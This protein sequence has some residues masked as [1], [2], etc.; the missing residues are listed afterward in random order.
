MRSEAFWH[1]FETAARPRLKLRGASFARI[2]EH[3]DRFDR[4]VG[5]IETGCMRRREAEL[6]GDGGSTILF[7]KY[8]E[9]HPGSTVHT[10]DIDMAATAMCRELA[11]DRVAIAR[12]DSVAFLHGFA[13]SPPRGFM[14]LDL[15]Y[16]DASDFDAASTA[17]GLHHLRELTAAQPLLHEDTLVVVDE[18]PTAMLGVPRPDGGFVVIGTPG[19]GGKGSLVAEY[20]SRIG[21]TFAVQGF[22]AG[23]TAM[24]RGASQDR[25]AVRAVIA[26]SPQGL[27]AVGAAD[28]FVGKSQ[29]EAGGYGHEEI[30]RAAGLLTPG[31]DVLVVGAHVGSIAIPLARRCRHLT[32]VEANPWTSKLLR[33]NL[34]LN[35]AN[36]VTAH[37]FAASD[38]AGT[39][40][41]VMNT[42]NSGGSKRYPLKPDPAY[43]YDD[44]AIVDVPCFALDEKLD[45]HDFVSTA[46]ERPARWRRKS[47]PVL[48]GFPCS[49]GGRFLVPA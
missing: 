10:V 48:V 39:I 19:I 8:A 3:L 11:G 33:C 40:R 2:F 20:A 26:G 36:N 15:L 27:F 17:A 5:I 14:S 44:P 35:D 12:G 25:T 4:P 34:V 21:A 37:H 47:L 29:L 13:A 1:Y 30:E 45:R 18:S 41:F 46:V 49:V 22:H 38:R 42:H 43:F 32:A 24:R 28:A 9:T 23:W 7:D 6:G 16:L 31:D